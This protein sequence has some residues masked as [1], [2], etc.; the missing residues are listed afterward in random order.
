MSDRPAGRERPISVLLAFCGYL[1]LSILLCDHRPEWRNGLLAASGGDA[2]S[3]VWFLHW[4]P[5][6]IG[7]GLD[8]LRS[9]FV[10][11]PHGYP[12]T[13]ATTVP[14]AALLALPLT[15][16]FGAAWSFNL[17]SVLAPAL[18]GTAAL[19]LARGCGT[20]LPAAM[21]CGLLYGF[22]PYEIGHLQGHLNLDL[23]APV[24]L[25]CLLLVRRTQGRLGTGRFVAGFAVCLL[26]EFG[27][28]AE[29]F[30]SLCVFGALGWLVFVLLCPSLRLRLFALARD[31]AVAI[32]PVGVVLVPWLLEMESAAGRIPGFLNPPWFYSADLLNMVLPTP[33]A[34]FGG[35]VFGSLSAHFTGNLAEQGSYLGIP[36]LLV[37]VLLVI[38]RRCDR[39]VLALLVLTV[40]VAIASLGP[41]LRIG[42]WDSR[43]PLPWWVGLHLP[44][45]KGALPARFSLYVGLGAALAA[46]IWLDGA[47]TRKARTGRWALLLLVIVALLPDRVMVRW[48]R[49]PLDPFFQPEHVASVLPSD[50]TVLVLPYLHS[51]DGGATPAMLWQWQ[52]G[53]RFRQAGG[54]LSFVPDPAAQ[55]PFVQH[56]MRNLPGPNFGNDITAL[57]ATS[58]LDAVVAGPGTGDALIS[59]LHELGWRAERF[60][61]VELFRVPPAEELR[62]ASLSGEAWWSGNG[63]WCWLGRSAQVVTHKRRAILH[64]SS[65]GLPMPASVLTVRAASGATTDYPVRAGGTADIPLEADNSY[66]VSPGA[67]F[68]PR[69][70]F[71][72]ADSRVLSFQVRLEPLP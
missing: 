38:E 50:A 23:T 4:W 16:L 26:A 63:G 42:G 7:H 1:L 22:G 57:A 9:A 17:L 10:Y 34:L 66:T 18:N 11:A 61:G 70:A 45:L 21:L 39:P 56:L 58:R 68:L 2:W 59:E 29:L 3:F 15:L 48:S 46:A 28:S 36:L 40:A 62:Y 71:H 25:A 31:A 60:G 44:L 33:L 55:S 64:V 8:P 27:L 54:Y 19:L 67:T 13:W 47:L 20:S 53:M 5:W 12:L 49:M 72:S 14:T 24:P 32:V 37:L 43:L 41:S 35:G 52:S 6:A 51:T 65:V 69:V 30:A